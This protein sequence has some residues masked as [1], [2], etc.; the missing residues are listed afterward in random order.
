MPGYAGRSSRKSVM[1]HS[2]ARVPK[3]EIPRSSFDRS[4]GHKTTLD[5]GLLVPIL[6]DEALPGDTFNLRAQVFARLSTPLFP[7]MDNMRMSFFFFAIPHRLLWENWEKFCGAQDNPADSTD[8]TIPVKQASGGGPGGLGDYL[9]VP[10]G[11]TAPFFVNALPYRAV[12][13][14]WNEWFRDQNLQDSIV[15]DL[16]DGPDATIVGVERRGKRHDYFTSCLPF[17]QKGESVTLPLGSEAP[18]SGLGMNE[19]Q[20]FPISGLAQLKDATGAGLTYPKLHSV[21]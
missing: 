8:F 12:A 19:N 16:S 14:V 2:F 6:V 4:H 11:V 9:G 10:P 3:A 20:D 17:P 13:L 7:T 15:I 1:Q 21:P 18:I 5:A